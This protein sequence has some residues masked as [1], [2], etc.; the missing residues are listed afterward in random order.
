MSAFTLLLKVLGYDDVPP[1]SNPTSSPIDY[2]ITQ[3]NIPVDNPETR[4]IQVDPGASV[5]V[6]NGT[7]N[8]TINNNTAFN[9]SINPTTLNTYRLTHF[10][11]N[12]PGFRTDRGADC[13]SIVLTLAVLPNL[14]LQ[15]TAG[16]GTPFASVVAGDQVFI[17]G[18]K[19]G[20]PAGPFNDLNAG[21]WTVLTVVS[22]SVI[23]LGRDPD[24][25]WEGISEVVT[26]V[27]S[28]DFQAFSATGVQ[29]GDTVDL[30]AGFAAS[31]LNSYDITMVTP[32][33]IEFF[34]TSPLGPQSDILPTT[35]GIAIYTARKRFIGIRTDQ[36]IVLQF[37][38]DTGTYNRVEPLLA[39]TPGMEGSSTK[40]G[41][42]WSLTI[43]NRSTARAT[44][45]VASA[46]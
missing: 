26:P 22:S 44:V 8:T 12:P 37:N 7:R 21:L 14:A 36:S 28:T 17:P 3:A 5:T 45:K 31:A 23:V 43:L 2:S 20:D 34:S 11:G 4:S 39:G 10:A 29:I 6:F 9:L 32:R 27:A 41:S 40:W 38:G 13:S 42:V 30:S 18:V 35:A 33:W 15:V 46:E 24:A 1:T 16:S 19:T 25:V